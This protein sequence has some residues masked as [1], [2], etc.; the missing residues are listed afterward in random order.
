MQPASSSS[1]RTIVRQEELERRLTDSPVEKVVKAL[2]EVTGN[3][4]APDSSA[5]RTEMWATER[6]TGVETVDVSA[7]ETSTKP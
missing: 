3:A 4:P 5:S 7:S 1:V 6:R 2:D